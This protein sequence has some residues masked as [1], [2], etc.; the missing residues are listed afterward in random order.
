[1]SLPCICFSLCAIPNRG[2]YIYS[3]NH[4]RVHA[5]AFQ[6]RSCSIWLLPLPCFHVAAAIVAVAIV[7]VS[8]LKLAWLRAQT[9]LHL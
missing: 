2:E 3:Q 7:A 5:R 8:S 9:A 1:M 6:T 4:R